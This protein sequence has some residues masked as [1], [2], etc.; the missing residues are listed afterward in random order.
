[1]LV[2]DALRGV[3]VVRAFDGPIVDVGS[4]NGSPGLVLAASLPD[5]EVTLLDSNAAQGRVPRARGGGVPERDRGA[6]SRRGAGD[7]ISFGVALAKALAPPAVALEWALPLVSRGRRGRAL[8]RVRLPISARSRGCRSSSAARPWRSGAVWPS[9]AK[10]PPLQRVSRD[11]PAW[12]G[13][14]LSP[15]QNGLRARADLRRRQPEGRGRQDDHCGQPRR[16]PREGGRARAARRSRPAGERDLGPRRAARTARP[17]ATCS[18]APRR[19]SSRG[20]R[21]SRTST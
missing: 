14:V 6:R 2:D 13:N 17:A 7:R 15:D 21:A 12:P 16:L 3:E 20:R 11:G 8:A 19:A 1:M 5:R 4:G 18:T 10:S 9:R